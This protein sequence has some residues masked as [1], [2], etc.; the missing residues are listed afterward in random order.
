M[1]SLQ[2][3][4]FSLCY[5]QLEILK[6]FPNHGCGSLTAITYIDFVGS[7]DPVGAGRALNGGGGA[8]LQGGG[9][10]RGVEPHRAPSPGPFRRRPRRSTQQCQRH[11]WPS[12]KYK[13]RSTI[14]HEKNICTTSEG[15]VETGFLHLISGKALTLQ[16][17]TCFPHQH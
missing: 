8:V 11:V 14:R 12:C 9:G 5:E 3:A 16:I 15:N 7:G 4:N 2:E 10:R 6:N 1:W 17:Y 13:K